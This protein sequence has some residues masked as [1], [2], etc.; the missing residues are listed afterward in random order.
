M[1]LLISPIKDNTHQSIM[2]TDDDCYT[3]QSSDNDN[4]CTVVINHQIMMITEL[5]NHHQKGYNNKGIFLFL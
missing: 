5:I 4:C 3:H 1:Y 2:I